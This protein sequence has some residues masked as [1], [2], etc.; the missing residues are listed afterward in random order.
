[1]LFLQL[2]M[3]LRLQSEVAVASSSE[4]SRSG[5]AEAR[6][7]ASSGSGCLTSR[8]FLKIILTYSSPTLM[9]FSG[10]G[11]WL[12]MRRSYAQEPLLSFSAWHPMIATSFVGKVFNAGRMLLTL[13]SVSCEGCSTVID[14]SRSGDKLE[15][16]PVHG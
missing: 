11:S 13:A 12:T 9:Y 3:K 8:S 15:R 16:L 4:E 1:M 14:I 2:A 10:M 7:S 5:T 6:V